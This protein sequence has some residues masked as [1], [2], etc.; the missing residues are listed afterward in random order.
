MWVQYIQ[1]IGSKGGVQV[2]N[3]VEGES[4]NLPIW[5]SWL[6]EQDV[7]HKGVDDTHKL[8]FEASERLVIPLPGK[9]STFIFKGEE[10]TID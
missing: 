2:K 3:T 5:I 8:G 1:R 10:F 4:Q 7:G 9:K 6:G